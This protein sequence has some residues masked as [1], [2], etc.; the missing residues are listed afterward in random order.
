MMF[1]LMG[2][3]IISAFDRVGTLLR[4]LYSL[5]FY[6]ALPFLFLRLL[7]RSRRDSAYRERWGERLGFCPYQFESCIWVH[8]VSVGE[9][10][11]AVPLVK[12]LQAAYPNQ[13]ILITTM[14]I[15][16]AARV[17]AVFGNSVFQAY[18]PYDVPDAVERFLRRTRPEIAIIF[19]TELWPNLFAACKRNRIPIMLMN[20]RLSEKSAK[21]YRKIKPLTEAML[22][23]IHTLAAQYNPDADRFIA[24]GAPTSI[25]AV[26]GNLKF[27][28]DLPDNLE[29]KSRVLREKIGS[30]RLVW[31]AASTHPDEEE[32]ILNAHRAI[33]EK[34]SNTL[35][36]L[37]PRHPERFNTVAKLVEQKGFHL[38]RRSLGETFQADVYLADTMGEL[39][40]LYS[41]ADVA[42][43]AGSFA[44]VGGHNMLE[45]AVLRKPIVTGPELYNFAEISE[46]LIRAKGLIVV[47][48]TRELSDEVLRLLEEPDYRK[49]TGENA[50]H[51]VEENRGALKKQFDLIKSVLSR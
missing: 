37:V 29:E 18:A 7:W 5:L 19:E 8:T 21:G 33:R 41:I 9:T 24:L 17:K 43:V 20:A 34:I 47:K 26:T 10:L 22:N 48:N 2:T 28:I 40:L 45:P 3:N 31:I 23:S 35:L 32:I 15:T 25:V 36:I 12:A 42:F 50:Y 30:D 16:G 51:T 1:V 27:D 49:K 13:P 38:S 46:K 39:L 4:Y 6:L 11:A 14:T 44:K